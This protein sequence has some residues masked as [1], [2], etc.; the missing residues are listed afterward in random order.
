VGNPG[1]REISTQV[2]MKL[3]KVVDSL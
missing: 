3:Q 2:R 1:L